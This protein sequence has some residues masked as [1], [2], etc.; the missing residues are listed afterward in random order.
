MVA[1]ALI[2]WIFSVDIVINTNSRKIGIFIMPIKHSL[3]ASVDKGS[4]PGDDIVS[5]FSAK[6]A[7]VI[8]L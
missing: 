6:R 4:Y 1:L 8:C 7:V 5:P 3:D 2:P